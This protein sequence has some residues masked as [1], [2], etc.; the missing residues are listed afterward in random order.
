MARF[1]PALSSL[2]LAATVEVSLEQ[3]SLTGDQ[4]IARIDA[5]DNG[6]YSPKPSL[7]I[8]KRL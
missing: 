7:P 2:F 8:L 4:G 3:L 5:R 1:E 6:P